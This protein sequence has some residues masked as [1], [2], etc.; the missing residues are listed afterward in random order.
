MAIFLGIDGGATKTACVVADEESILGT[1][2]AAGCNLTRSDEPMVREALARAIGEACAEAKV[3]PAQISRT[4]IGVAGAGR[5][6]VQEKLRRI[7]AGMV[8]GEIEVVEDMVIALEAAFGGD[9]GVVVIA[10]HRLHR[11]RKE[12]GRPKRAGGWLGICDLR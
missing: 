4:C 6:L 7:L 8:N 12:R 10:G 1:G 9:P 11:L 2:A 3:T 5:P